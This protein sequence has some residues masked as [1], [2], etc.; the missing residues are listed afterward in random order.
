VIVVNSYQLWLSQT[1]EGRRNLAIREGL[2]HD[3]SV[4]GGVMSDVPTE[5]A[6]ATIHARHTVIVAIISG[7]VG[8]ATTLIT[9]SSQTV[10]WVIPD[11]IRIASVG[12]D[13]RVAELRER[14]A[15]LQREL[16]SARAKNAGILPTQQVD[17]KNLSKVLSD[18]TTSSSAQY[19]RLQLWPQPQSQQ[20]CEKAA[21]Q[22]FWNSG[23]GSLIADKSSVVG[24]RGSYKASIACYRSSNA[25]VLAV[26]GPDR[27][28]TGEALDRLFLEY[29]KLF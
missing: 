3:M 9:V 19:I 15:S 8:V 1:K 13:A 21:K 6:I 20:T 16:D 22:A 24:Q 2:S 29:K 11:V 14:V 26:V 12:D 17:C 10:R 25:A 28:K 23:F 5:R 7:L 4:K 27:A 18:P